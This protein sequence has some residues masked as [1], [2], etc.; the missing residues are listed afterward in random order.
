MFTTKKSLI[1][2]LSFNI[3]SLLELVTKLIHHKKTSNLKKYAHI[4]KL[5]NSQQPAEA[6]PAKLQNKDID[7]KLK[8]KIL[9]NNNDQQI[10]NVS[11]NTVHI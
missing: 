6:E 9:L 2:I 8:I 10:Q 1:N 3:H 11:L 5:K 7:A 4:N